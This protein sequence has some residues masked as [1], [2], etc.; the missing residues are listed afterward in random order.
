MSGIPGGESAPDEVSGDVSGVAVLSATG[1]AASFFFDY[2]A[3][4]ART[5]LLLTPDWLSACSPAEER[6]NSVSLVAI[7]FTIVA[8]GARISP[9]SPRRCW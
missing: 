8:S 9:S 4:M 6:S 5:T 2:A 1:G 3:S 7:V